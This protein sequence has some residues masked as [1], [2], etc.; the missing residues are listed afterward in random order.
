MLRLRIFTAAVGLPLVILSIVLG[1][2][3]FALF[4]AVVGGLCAFEIIRLAP[5]SSQDKALAF[6]G[7]FL[8]VALSCLRVLPLE[9]SVASLVVTAPIVMGLL[10]LLRHGKGE[11]AFGQWSWSM[12][13][14]L[15]V[16]FL[17]GH[18]GALYVLPGG[19]ALVCFGM[20]TTFF[21]DTFAFFTGRAVGK[22]KMAPHLSAG[23]TWEGAAGGVLMA[24]VGGLVVRGVLLW[25]GLAF[26]LGV[27]A[28]AIAALCLAIAAQ[29][30][31]LVESAAKRSAGVKDAGG[32][33]PGHGGMLDRFDSLLF[34]GPMLYYVALWVS[35]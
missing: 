12:S 1:R 21:Y 6:V 25:F 8:S 11:N 27:L 24:V 13:G 14:A 9:S 19:V 3:A 2:Y 35:A 33:L 15:Y 20:F 22:H 5:R 4:L 30:G 26:P 17:W 31:D 29:T 16:G 32:M 34:T 10:L 18:W 23:K 28:T 7:V